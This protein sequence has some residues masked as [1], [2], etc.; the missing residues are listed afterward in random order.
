MIVDGVPLRRIA[1][2]SRTS[3]TALHRHKGHVPATLA[4]AKEVEKV[5]DAT[6]L[7]QQV[8]ELLQQARRLTNAAEHA[9]NLSV[10]LNG[11]RSIAGVLTLLGQVSGELRSQLHL[12]GNLTVALRDLDDD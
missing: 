6:T 11:V 4:I 5:A 3:V 2:Q 7:L 10:D 8:Q 1:E 12:T 9:K